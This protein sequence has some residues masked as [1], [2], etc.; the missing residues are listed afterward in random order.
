VARKLDQIIVVDIECT[1]WRDGPPRGQASDIIEVGICIVDIAT[2]TRL[3][4]RSHLVRPV[5][6]TVSDFCTELT[7]LTQMQVE[8]GIS[9]TR[10]C[11]LLQDEY[12]SVERV[13]ASYGDYDRQQFEH[14]CLAMG[15]V[16][17]FGPGHLNVKTLFALMHQLPHEVGMA[18]ALTM[19]GVPLEGTHHRGG[20]DAWNVAGILSALLGRRAS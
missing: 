8:N 19:L 14:Q 2:C 7:T 9:F 6:S 18:E 15:V 16:Y 11:S 13:W 10:V 5:R 20:D 4:K 3:G 12:R 17:P 1:C